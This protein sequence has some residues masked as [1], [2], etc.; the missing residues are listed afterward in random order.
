MPDLPRALTGNRLID[1][2]PQDDF[3]Q[4]IPHLE[5][6][7]LP[8]RTVLHQ[9][10]RLIGDIYFLT[11]GMVSVVATLEDGGAVEVGVIGNEGFAGIPAL[12]GAETATHDVYMQIAGV[13][14]QMKTSA[15]REVMERSPAFR[16][17]LFRFVQF[18]LTQVSQ[19]AAC[20]VR[21]SV[22]QR[23]ARWLLMADDRAAAET[24]LLTQEF[25]AIMLGVQ[26]PGV[27]IAAGTLKQ[28]GVIAYRHGRITIA[29]R[30]ALQSASCECYRVV[31]DEFRRLFP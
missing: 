6:V 11:Q 17:N 1:T 19:T 23:L 10:G 30:E 22:E 7:S 3:D 2:L 21:H 9:P 28:A 25:L 27:S 20:N 24:L 14:L 26:R 29:D 16:D 18:S 15:M 12:L 8:I 4:V 13:G 31:N 5:R